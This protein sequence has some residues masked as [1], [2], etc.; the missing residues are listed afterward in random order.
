MISD[1]KMS[2]LFIAGFLILTCGVAFAVPPDFNA[3]RRINIKCPATI[4]KDSDGQFET[5]GLMS[6]L[7]DLYH[8]LDENLKASERESGDSGYGSGYSFSQDPNE[9]VFFVVHAKASFPAGKLDSLW[10]QEEIRFQEVFYV[11]EIDWDSQELEIVRQRGKVKFTINVPDFENAFIWYNALLDQERAYIPIYGFLSLPGE[12]DEFPTIWDSWE[13]G[14]RKDTA[15]APESLV[16]YDF[17]KVL[18]YNDG[19]YLLAKDFYEFDYRDNI[20]DFGIIGWVDRKYITL[21]RSRLYYHPVKPVQ[22]F[23]DKDGLI[24]S[25]ETEEINRFYVEH[26]YLKERLFS[27]IVEK[28]DQENLHRFYTHFGFPQLGDPEY[29]DVGNSAEVF[30]PGSFSPR[31]MRLLNRSMKRNLNTFFLLDVS[32]SMR[33]FSDYVKSFNSAV[34]D[35][36]N[37]GISLRMNR[38][39]AYWDSSESDRDMEL[40]PNFIR[41]KR[42]EELT[43]IHRSMDNNYAEPLMRAFNKALDEVESLQKEGLILPLQE[44]LFFIITDAGANDLTDDAFSMTVKRAQ[45]LNLHVYL[46]HPSDSGVRS[47]NV[48]MDD[49]PTEAY[50]NLVELISGYEASNPE[51]GDITFRRF[52][53]S[54]EKLISEEGR[55]EDFA[56]QHRTLLDAIQA[57][58]DHI[59]TA[60]SGSGELPRDVVLYFSD[61]RLLTEMRNWS[62]R[63]I[64]VLNHVIKHIRSIDDP[65]VWEERI[66]IPAKP[67]ESFLRQIRTQDD[68]S[69]S[70][71]KKLV[72]INSLVSVDD[73]ET[74]RKLYDHIKPLIEMKTSQSADDVFYKA[75][76]RRE[77]GED[78]SWNEALGEDGGPLEEYLSEREFHLNSFNQAV[79]RK[80]MY[81]KVNELYAQEEAGYVQ[82]KL[83]A[84]KEESYRE[85]A[86]L[87]PF[88]LH[89]GSYRTI[90][91]AE[92]A[93]DEYIKEDIH[94][95]WVK[96]DLNE[97]GVWY[98]IFTGYFRDRHE[99]E[100]FR[101]EHE[102]KDSIIKNTR[103]ANLIGTYRTSEEL[104]EKV[105]LLESLDYSSFVIKDPDGAYC[106]YVGS[107]Y[108]RAMAEKQYN[109]LISDNIQNQ[110]VER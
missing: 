62:D 45:D 70:D 91:R 22:F 7:K 49:S 79:Q 31:L 38:I 18:D 85:T 12:A 33:P 41:V 35:M 78:T 55:Q 92:K 26:V 56:E 60:A 28:L 14:H 3:D 23:D 51:G 43:F 68:V 20:E 19:Y 80:F 30:V 81:I 102:L 27:D 1:M 109:D 82:E 63:R 71:L 108:D 98:R 84:K 40:D 77:P 15:T 76:I 13:E 58:M 6:N 57:Y 87:F 53:F 100:R 4:Y 95:Y 9:G 106:L 89:I 21:W 44:K 103:Y 32:E 66:A 52:E 83:P 97:K 46:I 90:E 73:I 10:P 11:A 42:P 48:N 34:T 69:L 107:F 16:D 17:Y 101:E 96:V 86:P 5:D 8:E 105:M 37:E 110:I 25:R 64:Q 104:D 67:V 99:A 93:I 47:P 72:I 54:T 50:D 61:E 94:A 24:G 59:F 74:C 29:S 36:K 75:L 88:S 2:S 39:Y 65:M